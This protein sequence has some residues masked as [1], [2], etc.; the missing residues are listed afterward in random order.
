VVNNSVSAE[1][2]AAFDKLMTLHPK[3]SELISAFKNEPDAFDSFVVMVSN[4]KHFHLI[5]A[6]NSS[7]DGV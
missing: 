1:D 6:L 5:Y 7:L 4:L 3:F 2:E